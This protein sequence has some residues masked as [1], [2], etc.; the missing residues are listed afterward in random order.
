[1][2]HDLRT[3]YRRRDRIKTTEWQLMKTQKVNEL[4]GDQGGTSSACCEGGHQG[5]RET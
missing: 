2:R 5:H 1:M 3:I 4:C